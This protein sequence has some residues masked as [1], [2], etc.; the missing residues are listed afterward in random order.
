VCKDLAT[1]RAREYFQTG[2]SALE[3]AKTLKRELKATSVECL[4]HLYELVLSLADSINRHRL[5]LETERTRAA[6]ELLRVERAHN[7][8]LQRQQKEFS[9]RLKETTEAL[10]GTNK[11][12]DNVQSWLNFEMGGLIQTVK[13]IQIEAR[14][15][16]P[17]TQPERE[18]PPQ[19]A[20]TNIQ[21]NHKDHSKWTKPRER[22]VGV[23]ENVQVPRRPH[24]CRRQP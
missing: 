7:R 15:V 22:A 18:I 1:E 6:K 16:P 4:S 20:A 19:T 8:T 23:N 2:K 10:T 17:P 21:C 11:A 13:A 9:E 3:S 5:N 14:P 24:M 12:V